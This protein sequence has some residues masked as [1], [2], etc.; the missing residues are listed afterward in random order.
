MKRLV[1]TII[2]FALGGGAIIGLAYHRRTAT[3]S[4]MSIAAPPSPAPVPIA[5]PPQRPVV[6]AAVAAV[7]KA[8]ASRAT[9]PVSEVHGR[10]PRHEGVRDNIATFRPVL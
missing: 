10:R 5:A 9:Q 4:S 3:V 8:S 7:A 2:V 6:V 1:L